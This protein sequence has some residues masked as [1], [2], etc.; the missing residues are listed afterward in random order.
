MKCPQCGSSMLRIEVVF[1]GFVSC[2]FSGE[3]EFELIDKLLLDSNWDE[4]S[5]CECLRCDWRGVTRDADTRLARRMPP[6]PHAR[7]EST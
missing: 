4:D 1:T 2:A 3:Q 5:A 6:R 7:A